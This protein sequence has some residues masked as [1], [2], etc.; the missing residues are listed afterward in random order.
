MRYLS[1]RVLA[2]RCLREGFRM[3]RTDRITTL[4]STRT[5]FRPRRAAL[6]RTYLA[7]LRTNSDGVEPQS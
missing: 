2:W 4:T 6:L 7:E 1:S 5:S 3:F